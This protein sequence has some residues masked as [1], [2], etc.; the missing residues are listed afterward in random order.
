LRTFDSISPVLGLM[1]M[2]VIARGSS[3][4]KSWML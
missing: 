3:C 2:F 4:A 1:P